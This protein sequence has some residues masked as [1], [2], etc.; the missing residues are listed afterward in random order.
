MA[1]R[2]RKIE[3]VRNN[4]KDLAQAFFVNSSDFD[5][6]CCTDYVSLDHNPE[7]LTGVKKIAELIGSMTIH[8]MENTKNGDKRIINELS[9]KI[10][11]DPIQTMTRSHWMESI[12]MNLLLYG[13]GNSIVVPH[14][15]NGMIMSLEPISASRVSFMPVN[16]YR[17]YRIL[18]DGSSKRPDDVLH[19]VYNPDKYYFWK[20]TGINVLLR[21]IANN[22]KQGRATEKGFMESKWK[23]S[24]IV[25]VDSMIEQYQTTEGREK[26]LNSYVKSNNAGEPWLLPAEQ[27]QVEQVKPLTLQDLAIKDTMELDKK[28]VASILGIPSFLLG[29]G[30][31]NRDEWNNFIQYTIGFLAKLIEQEMTRKLVLNP[32][33][34][35]KFNML[36]LYD[37]SIDSIVSFASLYDKGIVNK[38]EVRDRMGMES[39]ENGDKFVML[40]NFLPDDQIDKQKKV[41][42]NE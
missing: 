12:V 4:K 9:R 6:L 38:N 40:E 39:V 7:I 16:G 13:Q 41:V 35:L 2:K 33:W 31:F 20:G 23:P 22:L 30:T 17:N 28:T 14:T 1:K 25:R 32:K 36:S 26:I 15:Y 29:V 3:S 37:Y 5:S 11:I 21:D 10:D 42:G 27:F 24:L 34:Y 18:I 8:L 19:F